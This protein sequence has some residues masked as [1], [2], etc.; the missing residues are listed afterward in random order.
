[1][2][3]AIKW[4]ERQFGIVYTAQGMQEF[5]VRHGFVYKKPKGIPGKDSD[6]ETQKSSGR[7]FNIH[8]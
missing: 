1:M 8:Y 7:R 3:V 2:K 5:L 4:V 6:E